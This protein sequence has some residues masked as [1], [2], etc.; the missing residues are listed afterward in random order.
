M[1]RLMNHISA[2]LERMRAAVSAGLDNIGLLF[3]KPAVLR[4]WLFTAYWAQLALVLAVLTTPTLIPAG[5][6]RLLEKAYPPKATKRVFGLLQTKSTDPRLQSRKQQ[7]RIVLWVAAGGGVLFLFWRHMPLAIGR[8]TLLAKR[9]EQEADSLVRSQPSRSVLLYSSA[10][11]LTTDPD[12]EAVLS[13]KLKSLDEELSW[14]A[15]TQDEAGAEEGAGEGL[16]AVGPAQ[17]YVLKE[18]LGRGAMGVVYRAHD[19]RLERDVALKQLAPH[20]SHDH[21]LFMR[22]KQEA[23]A[24]ARLSHP[25][26]VQVYDFLQDEG[27]AW[28]AM[29]LV[30]GEELAERLEAR[31]A[32]S[33]GETAALGAQ[34]AEAMAYAHEQGVVHR[35]FKPANVLVTHRG[36]PKITDFG[37]AKL[38]Q[39]NTQTLAGTILGSPAYMSP[40][41]GSGES[42]DARSDIYALGVTLYEM[43]A[44]AVPFDG[45]NAT[46]VIVQH[47]TKPPTPLRERDPQIPAALD[48][49][50]MAMLAK[51]PSERPQDMSR[52]AAALHAVSASAG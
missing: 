41:Q 36:L 27:H 4:Y 20:I 49:L 47:A 21:A 19:R 14:G 30:D 35:D 52:V 23:R 37:M 12:H 32:M 5:L 39:S 1:S 6:D 40:E 8:A 2:R 38:A 42:A 3:R 7:A 22:F 31:G 25:N 18:E 51:E 44:G 29:E 33:P 24:L 46:A 48:A 13:S 9:R 50:I 15:G 10:L 17:R 26:I 28:I 16:K 11:A 43:L 34:L 45:E